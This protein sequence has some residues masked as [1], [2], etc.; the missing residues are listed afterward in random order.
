M[1][2]KEEEE[3]KTSIKLSV[4]QLIEVLCLT[5]STGFIMR[6]CYD[7]ELHMLEEWKVKM[8]KKGIM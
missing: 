1:A 8:I 5:P 4:D 2:K 6:K 3:A 7:G